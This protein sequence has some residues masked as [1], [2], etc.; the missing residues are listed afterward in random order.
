MMLIRSIASGQLSRSGGSDRR[1]RSAWRRWQRGCQPRSYKGCARYVRS[2]CRELW[3]TLPSA[4]R[5]IQEDQRIVRASR[6]VILSFIF[7]SHLHAPP[8]MLYA[9]FGMLPLRSTP[10]RYAVYRF[11]V[12][13]GTARLPVAAHTAVYLLGPSLSRNLPGLSIFSQA[14]PSERSSCSITIE[15]R[16][17]CAL[18]SSG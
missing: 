8:Y 13:S 12:L 2:I 10:T 1:R 11:C 4:T 18:L 14:P 17:Y 3:L 9:P 5:S 16:L 15:A 7:R 6:S